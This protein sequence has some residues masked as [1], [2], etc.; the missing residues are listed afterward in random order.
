MKGRTTSWLLTIIVSLA[1]VAPGVALAQE[2]DERELRTS[3]LSWVRL[4]GAESCISTRALAE[5]VEARLRRPVIISAAQAD[6]SI[7]GRISPLESGFRA[8]VVVSSPDGAVLGERTIDQEVDDCRVLDERLAL[9]IAV[10]ID[11]EAALAPDPEEQVDESA[12]IE[13]DPEGETSTTNSSAVPETDLLAANELAG[14]HEQ[15]IPQ[16]NLPADA[17]P[18][19]T[20]FRTDLSASFQLGLGGLPGVAFGPAVGVI[21][22]PSRFWPIELEIG[23]FIAARAERLDGPGSARFDQVAGG[24]LL[25][26]PF[27][28]RSLRIHGCLG[29]HAGALRAEGEA[30]DTTHRRWRPLVNAAMRGRLLWNPWSSLVLRAGVTLVVPFIRDRFLFTDEQRQQLELFEPF[31]VSVTFEIGL[32]FIIPA[33]SAHSRDE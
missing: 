32:G 16:E 8:V 28:R 5:A 1:I 10:M 15:A 22:D 13:D 29:I 33:P 26:A 11:P 24:L 17:G 19:P 9:V 6:L 25:C 4:P 23:S 30:F 31:P 2:S 21:L 7:E 14:S 18:P 12:S 27:E 3:S 20:P